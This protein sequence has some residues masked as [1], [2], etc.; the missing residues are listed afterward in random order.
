MNKTLVEGDPKAPFLIATNR[1]E[2]LLHFTLDSYLILLSVKQGGLKY[3]FLS[4]LHDSTRDRTPVSRTFGE[5]ST[6]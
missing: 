3:H 1:G 4:L 5:H 2:G 6:H